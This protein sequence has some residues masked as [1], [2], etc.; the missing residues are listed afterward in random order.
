[1]GCAQ[2]KHKK[3]LTLKETRA[4]TDP[5]LAHLITH[6]ETHRATIHRKIA[7]LFEDVIDKRV[8]RHQEVRL[9]FIPLTQERLKDLTVVLPFYPHLK[10]LGLWKVKLGPEGM[11]NLAPA[12]S[13]LKQLKDLGL[14]DNDLQNEGALALASAL[15]ELPLLE[16]LHLQINS[17]GDPGI[18]AISTSLTGKVNLKTLNLAENQITAVGVVQ[19]LDQLAAHCPKL[20]TLSLAVNSLGPESEGHLVAH[21]PRLSLAKLFLGSTRVPPTAISAIQ[22]QCPNLTI[23]T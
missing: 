22:T 18:Q 6:L 15:T 9:G 8:D 4:P 13:G 16:E 12:L 14:E 11:K 17:I 5:L 3:S 19:L 7:P 21:L 1:M 20:T 2:A 10:R 23:Y